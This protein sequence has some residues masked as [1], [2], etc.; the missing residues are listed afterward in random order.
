MKINTVLFDLDGTLANSLPLIRNTFQRVFDEMNIDWGDD[1]VMGW[2]G[3]PLKD[4]GIHFAGEDRQ[5]DFFKLYQEY[6]AIDHD[7]YT[8]VYPGTMEML[9]QLEDGGYTMGVVTSKTTKVAQRSIEYL[10]IDKYIQV[11]IGVNDVDKHKPQPEPLY[12]A[13][14]K[15]N[16]TTKQAAYVGDSPFDIL[17]AKAAGTLAIAVPWGMA[18]RNVLENHKPDYILNNWDE[19]ISLIGNVE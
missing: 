12:A 19:L 2:I 13:L 10:G 5:P 11:L 16:R 18:E 6:Y 3:R 1:E 8:T 17:A 14:E 9:K 4:I 15:L 7:H